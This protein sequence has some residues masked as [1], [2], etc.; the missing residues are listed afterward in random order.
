MAQQL[1][2]K[3][4]KDATIKYLEIASARFAAEVSEDCLPSGASLKIDICPPFGCLVSMETA[5]NN[6][7]EIGEAD[8]DL[9]DV[10]E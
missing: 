3:L 8:A 7:Q 2:I 10:A 6:Y 1:V 4:N 9:V 5:G